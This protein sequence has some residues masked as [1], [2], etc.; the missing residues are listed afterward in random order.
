MMKSTLF[1]DEIECIDK[2]N[3]YTNVDE[4]LTS[5]TLFCTIKI[6]NYFTLDSHE[7]MIDHVYNFIRDNIAS[8]KLHKISILTIKHLLQLCL[9]NNIFSY[10][11]K[12]YTFTN[13][14]PTTSPLID[15]LANIYLCIWQKQIVNEIRGKKVLFG[16]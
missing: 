14:G 9:H 7:N 4:C 13:G 10:Q 6:S 16:R 12:I 3:R 2:L 11:N 8:N 15:T 5:T 1:I